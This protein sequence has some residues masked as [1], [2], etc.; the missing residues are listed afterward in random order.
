MAA[1]EHERSVVVSLTAADAQK[2]ATE[3]RII[4]L[5]DDPSALAAVKRLLKAYGFEAEAFETVRAFRDR[6][7]LKD[8]SCLVLDINLDGQCGIELRKQL[9]AERI[10]IPVI[11]VTGDDNESTK[12]AALQAGCV[13][14]LHKPFPARDLIDAIEQVT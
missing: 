13:A 5:D 14:Y 9:A 3:K 7:R 6:A 11:F 1:S 8:A 10:S 4:V 2:M 12:Q